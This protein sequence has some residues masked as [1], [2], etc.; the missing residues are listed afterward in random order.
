[1]NPATRATAR[2]YRAT[3]FNVGTTLATTAAL[4][5]RRG[6]MAARKKT[7]ARKQTTAR[8]SSAR[9][10]RDALALL[11]ADH[12]AVQQLFDQFEKARGEERKSKLAEKICSELKVHAQIEEEIFYPSLRGAIREE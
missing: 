12:Q 6:K 3:A 11:R 1:M 8:R 4:F 7:A 9:G 10:P 5:P 2:V